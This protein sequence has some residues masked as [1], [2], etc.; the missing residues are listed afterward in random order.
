MPLKK[1]V[2]FLPDSENLN[3]F[4]ARFLN[5]LTTVAR[6]II[7]FTELI[8]ICAF[9]SRFWLDRKNSDLSEVIRQRKAIIESTQ[10]FEKDYNLL[11]QRL[12][13][14]KKF[15]SNQPD[16]VTS[17][18][19]LVESTPTDIVFQRLTI[20]QEASGKD[21]GASLSLS[22]EKES[23]IIDFIT[24]LSINPNIKSVNVESIEK[25]EKESKYSVSIT[26]LFNSKS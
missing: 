13:Y 24:N 21:L 26:L 11:Q 4:S 18:N 6:F 8:V 1:E 23:S 10:D 3:S 15:Y 7:V 12:K 9:I 19:S 17:I 2:S 22:S 25:R 14:I 5:W 16:Y 20:N